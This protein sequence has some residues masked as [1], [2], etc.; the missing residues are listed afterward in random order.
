MKKYIVR[1]NGKEYEVE[2]EEVTRA[3]NDA[4]LATTDVTSTAENHL[5]KPTGI[6]EGTLVKAPMPGSIN[7]VS[8]KTGDQVRK[9][10]VLLILEAMKMMNEIP[11]PVSGK[12]VSIEAKNGELV[13]YN[14]LLM[15]LDKEDVS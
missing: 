1:L 9:G 4:V 13:D 14:S 8:V 12:I 7:D 2:M 10:D 11:A 3:E 5:A 6:G 15:I